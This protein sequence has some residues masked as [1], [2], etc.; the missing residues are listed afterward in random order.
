MIFFALS[1]I[2]WALVQPDTLL[3]LALL[4]GCALLFSPFRKAGHRILL[5]SL[6]VM[7]AIALLPLDN[8]L[9]LSLEKRYPPVSDE[10]LPAK[11]DGVIFLGGCINP[12][13]SGRLEQTQLSGSAERL[14]MMQFFA[15]R[16]PDATLVFTGGSGKLLEQKYKEAD[17]LRMLLDDCDPEL[18]ERVIFENQSRNTYENAVY[19]KKMIAPDT[20]ERWLLVTSAYHMRR[21]KS[22][23]DHAGWPVTPYPVDYQSDLTLWGRHEIDFAGNMLLLKTAIHE[24]IGIIAY[25]ANGKL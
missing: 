3:L 14:F 16:Y 25:A 7:I 12:V 17:Y 2:C 13:V 23:F 5:V 6:S 1:K 19:S 20:N 24:Y 21:S 11:L 10:Q 8:L 22:V 15:R 9:V 18:A 4:A